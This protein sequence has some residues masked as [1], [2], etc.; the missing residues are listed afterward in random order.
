MQDRVPNLDLFAHL[1]LTIESPG[2]AFRKVLIAEHKNFVLFF[3]VFLGLA[4]SFTM[5]WAVHAGD[6]FDNLFP[7]MLKG[8]GVGLVSGVP[9]VMLLS[10]VMFGVARS[11]GGKGTF[12][13]TYG[14]AGWSLVPIVLSVVFIL[15]LE[16]GTLG[17]VL[18]S[19]NPSAYEMKPVVTSILVGL[20]GATVVW[21]LLLMVTGVRQAHAVGR[22]RS[23]LTVLITVVIVTA[24][25]TFVYSSFNL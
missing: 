7:L 19:T 14:V 1:W 2:D 6:R 24:A 5:L 13:N 22:I 20:D 12:L 23:V 17:L 3:G 9:L 18:F 16:L 11:M 25:W 10:G 4:S 15:P 21:S 8:L